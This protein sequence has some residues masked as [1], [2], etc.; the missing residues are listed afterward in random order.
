MSS[1][2]RVGVKCV[3][4]HTFT[5]VQFGET[6]PVKGNVYTIRDMGFDEDGGWIR[7]REVVNPPHFYSDGGYGECQWALEK[8]RPLISQADDV[9]MFQKLVEGMKPTERLDVLMEMLD[10]TGPLAF[11]PAPLKRVIESRNC[12]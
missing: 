7:L 9:A 6:V 4:T 10:E 12:S 3:C 2:A 5:D 1:W 11:N 8:F